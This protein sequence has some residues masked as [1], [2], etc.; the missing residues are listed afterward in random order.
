LRFAGPETVATKVFGRLSAW[1][2]WI[3]TR[4]NA[5]GEQG[6][7]LVL[8]FVHQFIDH[9]AIDALQT[10]FVLEGTRA[11]RTELLAILD[12]EAR[13]GAIIDE[14]QAIQARQGSLDDLRGR[15]LAKQVAAHLLAAAGA[16]R[17]KVEGA[18]NRLLLGLFIA[19]LFELLLRYVL[20]NVQTHLQ[21]DSRAGAQHEAA[22]NKQVDAFRVIRLWFKG[23]NTHDVTITLPAR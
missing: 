4:P 22:I 10:Q 1:Q 6:A 13:E 9:L 12:P 11:A 20:P 5:T 14:I 16:V 23:S 19:K 2:N 17:E 15:L 21:D 8:L 18:V 3:F 7:L